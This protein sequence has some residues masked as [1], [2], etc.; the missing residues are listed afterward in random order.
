MT[1][2]RTIID[3]I[4]HYDQNLEYSVPHNEI[5]GPLKWPIT[6][7]V[8][9]KDKIIPI[10]FDDS[11]RLHAQQFIPM[12]LCPFYGRAFYA[13]HTDAHFITMDDRKLFYTAFINRESFSIFEQCMLTSI[14]QSGL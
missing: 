13:T 10:T 4:L 12:L 7:G 2:V 14:E 6:A 1:N 9:L 8:L 5:Y 3:S 11:T